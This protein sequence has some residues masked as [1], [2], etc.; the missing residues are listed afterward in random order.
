VDL[1]QFAELPSPFY[2]VALK[3]IILD[4]QGRLLLVVNKDGVLEIPGGGWEHNETMEQ[5]LQRE[6]QEEIGVRAKNIAPILFT[7]RGQSRR[8]WQMLRLAMRVELESYNFAPSDGMT[9]TRFVT[10]A[11]FLG[12]DFQ[13]YEK[14]VQN[15]VDYIWPSQTKE[16][17]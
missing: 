13:D 17:N 2:R 16:Q 1:S 11:E 6:L 7:Y 5:G 10:R 8:G 3:A 15:M 14:G 9:A 4:D 12:L